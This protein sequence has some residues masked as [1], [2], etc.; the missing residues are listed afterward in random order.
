MPD[1]DIPALWC[2][3]GVSHPPGPRAAGRTSTALRRVSAEYILGSR[4]GGVIHQIGRSSGAAA[5]PRQRR[6]GAH[7]R[8]RPWSTNTKRRSLRSSSSHQPVSA[9]AFVA[10]VYVAWSRSRSWWE[11]A[12]ASRSPFVAV[13]SPFDPA[14]ERSTPPVCTKR[15][16][17]PG[18][19]PDTPQSAR[20]CR[21]LDGAPNHAGF[22]DHP[23]PG[24]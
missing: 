7:R 17:H 13:G 5:S 11:T 16:H 2:V 14:H 15:A 19:H 12:T 1:R 10:S 18:G 6:R 24:R 4:P 3:H 21:R 8:R 23:P 9:I 22:N 20:S